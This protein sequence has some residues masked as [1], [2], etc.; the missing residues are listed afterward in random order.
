MN[1]LSIGKSSRKKLDVIE[2][3]LRT[4][5]EELDTLKILA[6]ANLLAQRELAGPVRQ[7]QEAEFRVFSQFGDDGIIQYLIRRLNLPLERQR[8]V[9]FGVEDYSE[10]NT[11]FLLLHGNWSGLIMDGN[12]D[13][14]KAVSRE[15]LSWQHELTA[16]AAFITRENI[17]D[18][19]SRHGF[20][21]DLGLLSIDIDGND[22][23]VW[24]AMENVDA[25]IV[26][27]E[28]NSVFGP[29]HTISVPYDPAFQRRQAHHSMLFWGA[30]L[31]ALTYMSEKKGYALV[32]CNSAG[33][34]AY[35]IRRDLLAAVGL[36]ELAPA[37]AYMA[38]KFRESRDQAGALT[39]LTG[40]ARAQAI[41]SLD[42]IEVVTGQARRLGDLMA[43]QKKHT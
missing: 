7:L 25:A 43:T 34:N 19:L 35:F 41:A 29:D 4:V 9:E 11:R 2:Q 14:M 31:S 21:R 12:A 3:R 20:S 18:L 40:K 28:Y 27:I 22:Y 39:F 32:G 13:A 33:N 10:A 23:W 26:I 1:P 42:V 8:F 6:A 5:E 17:N 36:P 16:V 30:S 24:E 38:S 37:Q 15:R